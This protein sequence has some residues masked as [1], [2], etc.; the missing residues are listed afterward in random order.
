MAWFCALVLAVHASEAV[1]RLDSPSD[2]ARTNPVHAR[3]ALT[4]AQRHRDYAV[5]AL[6]NVAVGHNGVL[7]GRVFELAGSSSAGNGPSAGSLAGLPIRL[8][9]NGK[10]VAVAAT[11]SQGRFSLQNLPEGVYRLLVD[12]HGTPIQR[13]FRVWSTQTAPPPAQSAIRVPLGE[14]VVRGQHPAAFPIMSLR[15][16][17]VLTGIAAGAIAAPVIYHN[18]RVD[19]RI[20]ASK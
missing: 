20:P 3:Q 6:P 7:P 18:A 1:E 16:A 17:G 19:N 10:T 13:S 9:R 5:V 15:Q 11:G 8:L 4:D 14:P 12:H 2:L